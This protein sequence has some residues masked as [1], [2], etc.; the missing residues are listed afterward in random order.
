LIV[1][2]ALAGLWLL[3]LL[4]RRPTALRVA[5]PDEAALAELD[6]LEKQTPATAE[7]VRRQVTQLS[8]IVRQYLD[9]RFGFR[10][11]EQTTPEFLSLL[12]ATDA[13][14][15][16]LKTTLT[17]ILQR[18]DLAKFAGVV[19]DASERTE[20]AGAIRRFITASA[21]LK[22]SPPPES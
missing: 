10:A 9:R 16:D 22:Q 13:L 11:V 15:A 17:Q 4:L 18:T 21:N 7:D 19:P 14:T 8:L 20:L 6:R 5:P 12:A 2:N 1:A 3:A